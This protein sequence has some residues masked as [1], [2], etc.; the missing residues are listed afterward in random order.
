MAR[1]VASSRRQGETDED[2]ATRLAAEEVHRRLEQAREREVEEAYWRSRS[3]GGTTSSSAARR[4]PAADLK[5]AH[6]RATPRATLSGVQNTPDHFTLFRDDGDAGSLATDAEVDALARAVSRVG[7]TPDVSLRVATQVLAAE[8]AAVEAV[9]RRVS[10]RVRSGARPPRGSGRDLVTSSRGLAAG[11]KAHDDS[12]DPDRR[13]VVA[14][15]FETPMADSSFDGWRGNNTRSPG[16]ARFE[17]DFVTH[18]NE[19]ED[20]NDEENDTTAHVSSALWG[21]AHTPVRSARKTQTRRAKTENAFSEDED[22]DST[23]RSIQRIAKSPAVMDPTTAASFARGPFASDSRAFKVAL[24]QAAAAAVED[25]LRQLVAKVNSDARLKSPAKSPVL[26]SGGS[27]VGKENE[28]E[29]Y[30]GT[31]ARALRRRSSNGSHAS[32]HASSDNSIEEAW[33]SEESLFC[34]GGGDDETGR[35]EATGGAVLAA[36]SEHDALAVRE[37]HLAVRRAEQAVMCVCK[38]EQ[39]QRV[40]TTHAV[41]KL[42]DAKVSLAVATA[43]AVSEE[44]AVSAA[45]VSSGAAGLRLTLDDCVGDG[46]RGV[47]TCEALAGALTVPLP[48]LPKLE[49]CTGR[50]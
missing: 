48:R 12:I 24:S 49:V 40:N 42:L 21:A 17:D 37:A 44:A 23:A 20:V 39:T 28:N 32:S 47:G 9:M 7:A 43:R 5:N 38:E 14:L 33:V 22:D 16:G 45:A 34:A 36:W 25:G 29:E 15:A 1:A 31:S 19:K 8:R 18:N 41:A 30:W 35:G 10:T 2:R 26:G 3:G 4:G 27:F 6:G 13:R 46:G 50:K 11:G